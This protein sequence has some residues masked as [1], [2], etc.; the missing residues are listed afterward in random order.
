MC[1]HCRVRNHT[2]VQNGRSSIKVKS[3]THTRDHF[4]CKMDLRDNI[5]SH[6][7]KTYRVRKRAVNDCSCSIY[8][9]SEVS[10]KKQRSYKREEENHRWALSQSRRSTAPDQTSNKKTKQPKWGGGW[11]RKYI[12]G[13]VIFFL[14]YWY[15][16]SRAFPISVSFYFFSFLNPHK[17]TSNPPTLV[18]FTLHPPPLHHSLV[19]NAVGQPK[20]DRSRGP[21]SL[22][23]WNSSIWLLWHYG[24]R[25]FQRCYHGILP[26]PSFTACQSGTALKDNCP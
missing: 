7:M 14:F 19:A 25:T 1:P 21:P 13:D 9:I 10:R 15:W 23:G 24:A 26:S 8:S 4:I 2:L 22:C 17:T 12:L 18:I 16:S 20:S 3:N 11:I 6:A 5:I